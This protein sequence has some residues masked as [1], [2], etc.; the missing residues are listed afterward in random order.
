M[1]YEVFN[2]LEGLWWIACGFVCV[3]LAQQSP[4]YNKCALS[5][6]VLFILFGVSDFGEVLWGS[7]FEPG[8]EW[9][10]VWKMV[11]VIGLLGV[12]GWYIAVRLSK[13]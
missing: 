3:L 4:L 1:S 2:I 8:M 7:F 10:L 13:R 5:A 11:N 9:L 6:G 12:F